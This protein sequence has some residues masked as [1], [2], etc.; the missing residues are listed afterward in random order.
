M[1]TCLLVTSESA[2]GAEI[3]YKRKAKLDISTAFAILIYLGIDQA[4]LAFVDALAL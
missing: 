2:T 1:P 4:C 3:H